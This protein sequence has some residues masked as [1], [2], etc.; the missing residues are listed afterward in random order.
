MRFVVGFV[1]ASLYMIIE[2]WLSARSENENRGTIMGV[3]AFVNFG[4]LALGQ[5]LLPFAQTDGGVLFFVVAFVTSAAILP[6]VLTRHDAP[7]L[8][9]AAKLPFKRMLA[10]SSVG[11]VGCFLNGLSNGPFWAMG[12]SYAQ[13]IELSLEQTA[14]FMT[15]PII[16]GALSAWP[17]GLFSDRVDRRLVIAT[18]WSVVGM[19][20]CLL[21]V[22]KPHG[23]PLLL[24]MMIFGAAVMPINSIYIAH[25]NDCIENGDRI[26]ISS[27]LILLYGTGATLGPPIAGA[28]IGLMGASGL[29]VHI[30]LVAVTGSAYTLYR[31]RRRARPSADQREPFQFVPRTTQSVTELDPRTGIEQTRHEIDPLPEDRGEADS[32]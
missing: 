26:A 2:S 18:L 7:T 30:A 22:L 12:T 24:I 27:G 14:L 19:M 13:K 28:L 17:V 25:V 11:V 16:A 1:A 3:Y 8:P 15:V 29:F 4:A 9:P 5:Q 31:T 6:I 10:L 20:G 23:T 21:I 32:N